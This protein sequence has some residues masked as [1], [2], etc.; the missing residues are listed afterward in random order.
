MRVLRVTPAFEPA[1]GTLTR[2]GVRGDPVGGLQNHA[3]H[4]TRA[5]DGEGVAQTVL[6]RRLPP[7]PALERLGERTRVVRLGTCAP[8]VP[9][10]LGAD[11]VHLHFDGRFATAPTAVAAARLHRAALVVTLHTSLRHTLVVD[12]PTAARLKA[13]GAPVE[14]WV[15]RRADAVVCLTQRVARALVAEGL[16]PERVHVIPSG[17][18]PVRF[19][20]VGADPFADV[21]RPRVLFHG[22]VQA[23]KG[24]HTLV[25]ALALLRA[26]ARLV[27]VGDGSERA[28][29]EALARELGVADRLRITGFVPHEQVPTALA[30]AD[31]AVLP[32]VSEELGTA[33]LEALHA[34]L[35]VVASRV[36]GIPEVIEDGVSGLLTPPGDPAAL[37]AALDRV[38]LE[39]GLAARLAAGGRARARDF[40]WPAL[41]QRV[42]GV[43]RAVALTS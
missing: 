21:A 17:V 25:R 1:P 33:M 37:A 23:E 13:R 7:S 36:G 39:P 31:V 28:R 6:T 40:S 32:S 41:A 5:L 19:A 14:G 27:L 2:R 4:L 15:T 12:S 11:V 16:A 22:R 3:A 10:A 43:Y 34:G 35:P 8:T 29:V 9:L 42:L 18:D 26:D 20:R 24:V 38:L 30:H